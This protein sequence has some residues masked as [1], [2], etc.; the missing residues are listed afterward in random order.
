MYICREVNFASSSSWMYIAY[1]LIIDL[2]WVYPFIDSLFWT[3]RGRTFFLLLPL[4]LWLTKRGRRIWVYSLYAC[5]MLLLKFNW[6]HNVLIC[7]DYMQGKL[8]IFSIYIF[9][10]FCFM[11][12]RE[13]YYL[14]FVPFIVLCLYPFDKKGENIFFTLT[15]L[16]MIDKK[17]E[18]YLIYICMFFLLYS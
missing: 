1:T 10:C 9:Y 12:K 2:I 7:M 18:K 16:L 6:Y 3:K 11:Q 4:C 5:F 8:N 14:C 17:G 13:K 15:P